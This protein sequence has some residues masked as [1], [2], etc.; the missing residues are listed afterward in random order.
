[1]KTKT[2]E[3]SIEEEWRAAENRFVQPQKTNRQD[4]DAMPNAQ[5]TNR[6]VL[7][8]N[9]TSAFGTFETSRDVRNSVAIGG[10]RT[11]P[12]PPTSVAIDQ[13]RT[14]ADEQ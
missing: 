6:C 9:I 12:V 8:G 2:A 1:M 7:G 10:K 3:Q 11:S 4:D 14:L 13:E 5:G